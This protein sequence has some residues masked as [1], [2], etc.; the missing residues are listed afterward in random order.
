MTQVITANDNDVRKSSNTISST[1][2][3]ATI[4]SI[5]VKRQCPN[6][7]DQL[8]LEKCGRAPTSGGGFGDVYKGELK[9]GQPVAIKCARIY[10]QED[11]MSGHKILKHAARELYTW[12]RL[13]HKNIVELLGLAEF[14]NH[15]AMVSPWM[16][17]GTLLQYIKRC[18]N[19][20]RYQLCVDIIGGVTYL[21]ENGTVHGDIKS[22]NVVVCR[23]GVAKLTD[24]GCTELKRTSLDFTTTSGEAK[25]SVRWALGRLKFSSSKSPEI[26]SGS[27]LPTRESDVYALGMTLLEALTGEIPFSGKKE[28]ALYIAI[29][30]RH[31][32]PE[33]PKVF[34]S[35]TEEEAEELWKLLTESWADD[36]LVRPSSIDIQIRL[37]G[38]RQHTPYISAIRSEPTYAPDDDSTTKLQKA[39]NAMI[40]TESHFL[41]DMEYFRDLWIIPLFTGDIIPPERRISCVQQIL[42]DTED[43]IEASVRLRDLFTQYKNTQSTLESTSDMFSEIG[44]CFD[45][46]VRYCQH[47]SNAEIA[48]E[49]ELALNPAFERFAETSQQLPK[50]KNMSRNDYLKLPAARLEEYPLLLE[51]MYKFTPKTS[52][53]HTTLSGLIEV[54][55]HLPERVHDAGSSLNQCDILSQFSRRVRFKGEQSGL[56]L[57]NQQSKLI[58]SSIVWQQFEGVCESRQIQMILFDNALGMFESNIV[59]NRQELRVYSTPVPLQLLKFS[60]PDENKER[61]STPTM[62]TTSDSDISDIED[63]EL[64]LV[65]SGRQKDTWTLFAPTS[66]ARRKWLEYLTL[67]Q[68]TLRELSTTFE[69]ILPYYEFSISPVHIICAAP[70]GPGIIYSTDD[71][72][73][74]YEPRMPPNPTKILQL[75]DIRQ[76]II[77]KELQLL[78]FLSDSAFYVDA[79]RKM[80]TSDIIIQ[81]EGDPTAIVISYPYVLALDPEFIEIRRVTDGALVQIIQGEN[82]RPIFIKD[83]VFRLHSPS[84][85]YSRFG[86]NQLVQ[87][88]HDPQATLEKIILNSDNKIMFLGRSPL[89]PASD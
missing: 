3:P 31:Q 69:T 88:Y 52:M 64:T 11:D 6:I 42:W 37:R 32:T 8:D 66:L 68:L 89:N 71:G 5:L 73:F 53:D 33:R 62:R 65:R 76:V 34:P 81:W 1:M 9:E 45:P 39:I 21:H 18:P 80:L 48:F 12:S 38:I 23:E 83:Q 87:S 22:S 78:L 4:I 75:P 44:L 86:Y 46:I 41:R 10:I 26:L 40:A 2:P 84:Y 28:A 72:L 85:P 77:L 60:I 67:Q 63:C 25:F 24:F 19:A 51:E 35:F 13:K 54:F 56:Q 57:L 20:D 50:A 58:H 82:I 30:V 47:Q 74:L 15:I 70:I 61:S 55:Q 7:T 16:E 17:N 27:G 14:R 29:S 49:R 36:P 59:G 43:V 79:N